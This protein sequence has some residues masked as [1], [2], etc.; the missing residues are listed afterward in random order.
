MTI[1]SNIIEASKDSEWVSLGK[2]FVEVATANASTLGLTAAQ[3]SGLTAT[4]DGFDS[5][6]QN[7][8][9]K[10]AEKEAAIAAKDTSLAN[11]ETLVRRYAKQWRGSPSV[12]TNS[13]RN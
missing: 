5:N 7:A 8:E 1:M 2:N 4:Y 3:V 12:S 13:L 10:I 6:M 9:A 11:F